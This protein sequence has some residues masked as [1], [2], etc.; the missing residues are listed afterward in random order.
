MSLVFPLRRLEILRLKLALDFHHVIL[1]CAWPSTVLGAGHS[2]RVEHT[3][4]A[5]NE[6][7]FIRRN[8]YETDTTSK[9]G[10]PAVSTG[11]HGNF[12]KGI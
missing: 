11:D 9:Q 7:P 5:L 4:P 3:V 2:K 6:L 12:G 1:L 10:N 8:K